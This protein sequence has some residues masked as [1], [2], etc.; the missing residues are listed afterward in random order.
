MARFT[1]RQHIHAPVA[2][3][4]EHFVD[5]ERYPEFMKAVSA[6]APDEERD[7]A[8]RFTYGVAGI[9]R[10]YSIKLDIDH[11]NHSVRWKSVDGPDHSGSAQF[12]EMRTSECGLVLDIDLRSGNMV[13]ATGA[14]L[15]FIR[16]RIEQDL[17]RFAAHVEVETG[18]R[19]P[20]DAPDHRAPSE[21]LFDAVFPTDERRRHP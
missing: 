17:H 10:S 2:R 3:T 18:N 13:D 15:G 5:F 11:E 8:M 4:F 7:P 20:P 9:T 14:V 6:V 21:R 12:R 19:P 16:S 1:V